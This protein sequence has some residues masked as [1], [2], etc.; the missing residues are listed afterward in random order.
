MEVVTTTLYA[1]IVLA[2]SAAHVISATM[3]MVG[4]ALVRPD[5]CDA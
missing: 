5:V 2:I 3:A 4:T 1:V